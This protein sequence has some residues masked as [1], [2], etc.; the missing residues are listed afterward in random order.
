MILCTAD[1]HIKIGQKNVPKEWAINRYDILIQELIRVIEEH[2][3]TTVV[4]PGDIFD[5]IPNLEEL[6]VFFKLIAA[7]QNVPKVII[8]SGNHEALTKKK[9]FL[10]SLEKIITRIHSNTT[11][12]LSDILETEYFYVVPY[13]FIKDENT[14]K[15][16]RTDKYLFTHVRGIIPPHVDSE[17]PLEWLKDFPVVFAGDLHSHSN[18]QLNIVYPGSPLTTSFHRETVK[19]GVLLIEERTGSWQW[20]PIKTPQML[21]KLVNNTESIVKSDYDLVV[22]DLEADALML[23]QVTEEE[24]ALLDKKIVSRPTLDVSL[25]LDPSMSVEQELLEYLQYIENIEG[26][27]LATIMGKFYEHF[28]L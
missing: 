4:I 8:S 21:K 13:E 24:A 3:V 28:N 14:W 15:S 23:K 20:E 5:K 25:T 16:L 2:N 27:E 10:A 6:E 22:Y 12:V 18:S 11:F 26:D 7:L 9:S 1:I 17:I 19:S